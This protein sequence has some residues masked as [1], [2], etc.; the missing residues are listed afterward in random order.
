MHLS[1]AVARCGSCETTC[2]EVEGNLNWSEPERVGH[3]I[4]LSWFDNRKIVE[5]SE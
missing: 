2:G 3:S 4:V 5:V 1:I